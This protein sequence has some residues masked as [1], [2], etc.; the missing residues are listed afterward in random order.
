M[1]PCILAKAD[2]LPASGGFVIQDLLS[3]GSAACVLALKQA[4]L[5]EDIAWHLVQLAIAES[6]AIS[7]AIYLV[8]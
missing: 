6:P 3:A 2:P 5:A 4:S 8:C 1:L 7:K